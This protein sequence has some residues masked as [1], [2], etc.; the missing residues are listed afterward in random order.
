MGKY[1]ITYSCGHEG[2]IDLYGKT[3]DRERKVEYLEKYGD[4]PECYKKK[5]ELEINNFEKENNLPSITGVSEKQIKY[6]QKIRY[7][8][9]KSELSFIKEF[10]D[11]YPTCGKSIE[12]IKEMAK[13]NPHSRLGI[14]Y[15]CI[16]ETN[17]SDIIEYFK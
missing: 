14:G 5:K 15:F 10:R 3:A 1:N 9:A 13:K 12:E 4:C 8:W 17:A 2:R 11:F 7:G 6:A 16:I